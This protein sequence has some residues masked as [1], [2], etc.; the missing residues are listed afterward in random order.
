MKSI[1]QKNWFEVTRKQWNLI[2]DYLNTM[3]KE[4]L[5]EWVISHMNNSEAL[6]LIENCNLEV[7]Q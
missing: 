4:D 1:E 5:I 7:N 2:A 3:K 6:S